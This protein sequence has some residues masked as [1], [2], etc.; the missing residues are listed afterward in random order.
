MNISRRTATV[1]MVSAVLTSAGSTTA[2]ATPDRVPP[3][4]LNTCP[5]QHEVYRAALSDIHAAQRRASTTAMRRTLH[6]ELVQLSR[7]L[8]LESCAC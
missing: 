6:L 5:I 7:D 1:L 3:E 2:Q 8:S 4:P